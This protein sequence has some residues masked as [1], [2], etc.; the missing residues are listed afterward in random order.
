MSQSRVLA[1]EEAVT[2]WFS[3]VAS[4]LEKHNLMNLDPSCVYNLDESDFFLVSSS[5]KVLAPKGL[6]SVYKVVCGDEK[7]IITVLFNVNAAGTMVPPLI[8][9]WYQ[10]MPQN[11]IRSLPKDWFVS[12][13]ETEWMTADS[14]LLY[15]K[16]QFLPWLIANKIELPIVLFVD[17]HVSH[18]TLELS[19]FCRENKIF[20]FALYPNATHVLQPFDVAVFHPLKQVWKKEVDNYRFEHQFS[21]I[22]KE[23]I[24]PLL[25]KT[26]KKMSNL[27]NT[28]VNG[29]RACGLKPFSVNVVD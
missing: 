25:E 28:I 2:E 8:L 10:R 27:K 9:Y 21:K 15:I 24:A 22:K 16:S 4:E 12:N 11:I 1:T 20:L 6:N 3:V 18:M 5:D 23:T 19:L 26:L 29:F 14:F 13:T 7:E 17:G